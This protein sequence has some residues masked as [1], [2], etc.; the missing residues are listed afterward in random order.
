MF[1]L[2]LEKDK[3]RVFLESLACTEGSFDQINRETVH[4]DVIKLYADGCILN[5]NSIH[6][7][8]LVKSHLTK[9]V[10]RERCSN[11]S[12]FYSI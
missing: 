5:E 11:T 6:M 12:I 2:I 1:I 7:T 9:V 4:T 10:F 8:F 3:R